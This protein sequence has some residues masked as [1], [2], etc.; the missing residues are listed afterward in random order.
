MRAERVSVEAPELVRV[1]ALCKSYVRRSSPRGSGRDVLALDDVDLTL[2]AGAT[3]AL[4]GQSGSGKSTLARCLALL[5]RPSAGEVWFEGIEVSSLS[6]RALTPYRRQLQIIFQDPATALNPRLRAVEIVSEPWTIMGSGTRSERHGRALE[7]MER[8]GLDPQWGR[9]RPLE[10]SGGQRQ[11]LAIARALA[12][13]PKL[14]I[15]DESLSG[16]D[17]S[18]Q[19]Q[20]VHLLRELQATRTLACLY[21]SHDLDLMRHV[22]GELVVLHAGRLVEHGPTCELLA[23]PQH[24]ETQALVSALPRPAGGPAPAPR[25]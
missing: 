19:A 9:R 11:R 6:G 24:P 5:E 18:V 15:L 2:R 3:M 25:A 1:R 13:E 14:L 4:V 7:L 22:A 20:I 10:L 16:L 12:L 21:V 23:N 8:V 17:P